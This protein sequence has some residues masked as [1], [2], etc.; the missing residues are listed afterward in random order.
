M[1]GSFLVGSKAGYRTVL[2]GSRSHRHSFIQKLSHLSDDQILLAM[3]EL[4]EHGD[5]QDFARDSLGDREGALPVTQMFVSF[6]EVQG[7]GVVD[8]GPDPRVGKCQPQ[9]VAIRW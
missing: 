4:R 8:A 2:A 1:R 6:L 9:S 3:T 7:N 5:R